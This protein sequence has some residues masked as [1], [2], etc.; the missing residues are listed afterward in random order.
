MQKNEIEEILILIKSG[1]QEALNIKV[2][3]DGTL[4]RRG[5]GGL[6][7]I[8]VSGMSFTGDGT[9]FEKL[10]A[11]VPQKVLD[12]PVNYQEQKINSPIEYVVA[13]FGV[14]KNGQTGERAEWTK[15]TGIRFSLDSQSS[16]KHPLLG[17]TDA[18][19]IE[20]VA[21][22]NPWYFDI[23]VKAVFNVKSEALTDQTMIAVPTT[24]AALQSAFKDYLSQIRLNG[25][26]WNMEEF[27]KGKTYISREGGEVRP[28][29]T[30]AE[31]ATSFS[32]VPVNDGKSPA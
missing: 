11:F 15:S 23:M 22:T 5:C 17:F 8:G 12:Q 3:K 25:R 6:P 30:F 1:Q 16:F 18:L 20:A 21:L 9:L 26:K 32:F 31:E 14:S 2:Y 10:L 19:S 27:S 4:C 7:E 29:F 13:F 28:T 24:E